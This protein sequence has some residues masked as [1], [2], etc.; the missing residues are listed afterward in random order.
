MRLSSFASFAALASLL[1]GCAA[2][3][4]AASVR[5]S[6]PADI[7]VKQCKHDPTD[8][9]QVLASGWIR[10]RSSVAQN[11]SFVIDWF[12]GPTPAAE[13]SVSES[14]VNPDATVGWSANATIAGVTSGTFTCRIRSVVRDPVA[15]P[16]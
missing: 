3:T 16:S 7:L 8:P 1:A 5:S 14:P 11:Y 4:P 12:N 6:G 9:T 15:A 10:S 2:S 13:T